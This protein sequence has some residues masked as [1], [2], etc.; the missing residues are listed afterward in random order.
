MLIGHTVWAYVHN[1][2]PASTGEAGVEHAHVLLELL[3]GVATEGLAAFDE[4]SLVELVVEAHHRE[5]VA[6]SKPSHLKYTHT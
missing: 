2:A 4:D 6:M 3:V 1:L 5:P